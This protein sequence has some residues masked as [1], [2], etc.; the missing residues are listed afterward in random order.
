MRIQ[1]VLDAIETA[2]NRLPTPAML[3]VILCFMVLGLSGLAGLLSLQAVHPVSGDTIHAINLLSVSGLHRI[4]SEAVTNFTSFA[5]VGTVLVAIMGVGV[6]EHSGLL[7][8]LLRVTI[9]RAPGQLLTFTI[10]LA[11]VLSSLAADTGY[12]VL[13]PLAAMVFAG[14]GRHPVA[15]IAAAFAGVS[16]GFSANLMIGPID[17]LLAGIST[18][19]AA[20]V[21]PD[22]EV[23]AAGNFYFMIVS[24]FVIAFIGTW[25]TEKIVSPRLS[26]KFED[27]QEIEQV[28]VQDKFGLKAVALFSLLFMCLLLVGLVPEAGIL[29]D[30]TTGSILSSPFMRGIVTIIAVY[31]ALAGILFG[32]VSGRYRRSSEFVDG[33]EKHMA[34]MAGYLV[35]MFFA[36]QFVSYFSWSNLGIIIAISGASLLEV[37]QINSALLLVGFILLAAFINLFIGS[38][39]AKWALIA[40]VFVPMLL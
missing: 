22:Y 29:R 3:F 4:I 28:S 5:P 8:A 17:A 33:M 16:G 23:N 2:G 21:Q 37:L 7:N 15:G 31:A 1:G 19:A 39:S 30:Q 10:V 26:G 27:S 40:P 13:I 24:T 32:R 34:T 6:A 11:G 18:E 38:A 14:A 12:V 36:S 9:L 35:L 20:L 25:I